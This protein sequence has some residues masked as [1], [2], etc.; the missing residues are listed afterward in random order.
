MENQKDVVYVTEIPSYLKTLARLVARGFYQIEDSLIVDMLV[1][2]QCMKEKDLEDLLKFDLKLLRARMITLKNE[3]LVQVRLRME[4]GPDGKAQ[5]MNYY[6]IN[7]K[8]LVNVIK[9]KLDHMRKRMET[10]ERDATNRAS[11]KCTNCLKTFTDLEA[12]ELFDPI[13]CGYFCTFCKQPVEEDASAVPKDSRLM[14]A[15]FNEQVQLLYDLLRRAE[16]IKLAPELLEPE[17]PRNMNDMNPNY[18]RNDRG[19]IWS[20]E[21]T[22]STGNADTKIDITIGDEGSKTKREEK[23][24]RP[25]WMTESTIGDYGESSSSS[26]RAVASE[27]TSVDRVPREDIMSL[28]MTFEKKDGSSGYPVIPG[29]DLDGGGEMDVAEVGEMED[30]EDDDTNVPTVMVG[31]QRIPITDVDEEV[32]A[33]MSSSEQEVYIQVCQDYYANV[34]D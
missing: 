25:I 23:K 13:S 34:L 3:K 33:K 6:F 15:K 26:T 29:Q 19:G 17:P 10:Q 9:Y 12:G 8:S 18:G 32:I 7:Y 24:E 16:D 4:T 20:G 5:K 28:L 21:A 1:R 31:T 22:R 27:T 2:N 30:D 11:F 14:L